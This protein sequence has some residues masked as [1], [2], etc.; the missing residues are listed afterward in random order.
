MY[1]KDWELQETYLVRNIPSLTPDCVSLSDKKHHSF[2]VCPDNNGNGIN[3]IYL[4]SISHIQ[5]SFE[6]ESSTDTKKV[7]S[8]ST[9]VEVANN[10]AVKM[11]PKKLTN[12]EKFELRLSKILEEQNEAA[13]KVFT[14]R[15]GNMSLNVKTKKFSPKEWVDAVERVTYLTKSVTLF[16]LDEKVTHTAINKDATLIAIVLKDKNIL[17]LYSVEANFLE[18]YPLDETVKVQSILFNKASEYLLVS[19]ETKVTIHKLN[20]S[21]VAHSKNSNVFL[22]TDFAFIEQKSNTKRFKVIGFCEQQPSLIVVQ[23]LDE[24]RSVKVYEIDDIKG[25]RCKKLMNF[26]L[27]KSDI[28]ELSV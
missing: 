11:R 14:R 12:K 26:S 7:N 3:I 23:L 27:V 25:G 9:E 15:S 22:E 5:N 28:T 21:F 2:L 8:T 13:S 20:M 18:E 10:P 6:I 1:V 16:E 19:T 17:K 4:S 24:L